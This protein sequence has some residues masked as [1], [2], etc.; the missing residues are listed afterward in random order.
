MLPRR[1][2]TRK[3]GLQML[4]TRLL[5]LRFLAAQPAQ[6]GKPGLLLLGGKP[7]CARRNR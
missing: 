4:P 1:R 3:A 7:A 2:A 5:Q 6:A